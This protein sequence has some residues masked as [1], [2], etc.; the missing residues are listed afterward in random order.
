MIQDQQVMEAQGYRLTLLDLQN[1]T[2]VAEVLVSTI[3]QT[4]LQA[5]AE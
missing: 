5:K 4:I 1:T 3:M 2:L